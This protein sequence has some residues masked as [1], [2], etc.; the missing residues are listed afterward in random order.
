MPSDTEDTNDVVFVCNGFRIGGKKQSGFL[1]AKKQCC[2]NGMMTVHFE[3]AHLVDHHEKVSRR[4]PTYIVF[5]SN[6]K[7]EAKYCPLARFIGVG[8]HI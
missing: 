2:K 7:N 6:K 8:W 1:K 5:N 4:L 3:V